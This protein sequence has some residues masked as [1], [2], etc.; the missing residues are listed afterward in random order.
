MDPAALQLAKSSL[1]AEESEAEVCDELILTIAQAQ[2]RPYGRQQSYNLGIDAGCARAFF[3]DVVVHRTG[4][5]WL[6]Q[7]AGMVIGHRPEERAIEIITM[8]RLLKISVDHV[9]RRGMNLDIADF[10]TLTLDPEIHHILTAVQISHHQP[11]KLF[12]A[13]P[14]I[15]QSRQNR[16]ITQTLQGFG[17]RRVQQAAGLA[18]AEGRSA[19]F[20]GVRLGPFDA[21]DRI[22]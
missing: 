4:E 9:Q 7:F 20:I 13:Q 18:F 19:A 16:P 2:L 3:D 21:I 14:V 6:V 15:E 17:V 22:S 11:T 10:V 8:S 1:L 12:T 5:K